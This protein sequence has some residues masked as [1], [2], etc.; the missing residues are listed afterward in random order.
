[1]RS[2]RCSSSME[3]IARD[4][5]LCAE[6]TER[7]GSCAG[8]Y[9]DVTSLENTAIYRHAVGAS[10]AG[11]AVIGGDALL[12]ETFLQF[13]RDRIGERPLEGDQRFPIDMQLSCHAALVHPPCKIDRLGP[14][15][16]HLLGIAAAE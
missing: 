2:G 3:G 9:Q 4:Q 15:N 13:A 14:A 16:E 6:K 12:G 1:M 8:C 11:Q 7:Y 10:E 5:V